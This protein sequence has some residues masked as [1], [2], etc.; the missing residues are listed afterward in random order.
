MEYKKETKKNNFL[1]N[2]L[3]DFDEKEIYYGIMF[4]KN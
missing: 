4:R 3:I 2:S 1:D